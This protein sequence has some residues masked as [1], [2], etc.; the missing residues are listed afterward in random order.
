MPTQRQYNRYQYE[1]S[2]RK[3]QP[4]YEPRRTGH[5]TKKST[6]KKKNITQTKEIPKQKTKVKGLKRQRVKLIL[7]IGLGFAVLF[8]I[9]Y[10]NSVINENFSQI[11]ELK[12][13]LAAVS[14]ENDQLQ[15]NIE[16]SL[17]LYTIEQSAKELLG[18]Q[19]ANN[20]QIR[21]VSLPK[22]DYVQPASTKIDL[23]EETS[24]IDKVKDFF[25]SFIK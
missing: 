16:N 5:S 7:G 9:C 6:V 18:M 21:Y 10:R 1:T 11:K 24:W 12:T 2:P 19:K 4:E 15:V 22:K 25:M 3:L 23:D 17:N 8:A 20:K 13:S 14:K